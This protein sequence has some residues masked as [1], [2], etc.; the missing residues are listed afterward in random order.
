MIQ[1]ANVTKGIPIPPNS[2]L[3][4]M[5]DA[6]IN[7]PVNQFIEV[8]NPVEKLKEQFFDLFSGVASPDKGYILRNGARISPLLSRRGNASL[9]FSTSTLRENIE[10]QAQ[11]SFIRPRLIMDFVEAVCQIGPHYDEK[12][13]RLTPVVRSAVEVAIFTVIPF[14]CYLVD[15]LNNLPDI[16]QLQLIYAAR[17]RGAGLY[18]SSAARRRRLD[19]HHGALSFGNGALSLS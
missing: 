19:F 16:I 4:L 14:D 11:I 5:K 3:V 9:L 1:F 13:S 18:F 6:S 17:R 8:T 2:S 12:L 10:F 15:H 7:L